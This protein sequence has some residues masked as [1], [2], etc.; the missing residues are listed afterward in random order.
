MIPTIESLVLL[1]AVVAAVAVV[2]T[3]LRM[4]AAIF[5]VL[6]GVRGSHYLVTVHR[7]NACQ[8]PKLGSEWTFVLGAATS[9]FDPLRT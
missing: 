1:L 9:E 2:A 8:G 6:T 4:P 3:R 7:P 5:L